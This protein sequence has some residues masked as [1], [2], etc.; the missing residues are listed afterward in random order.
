MTSIQWHHSK[1]IVSV[2]SFRRK[3]WPRIRIILECSYCY[4]Y[5]KSTTLCLSSQY[6][7][8]SGYPRS[9]RVILRMVTRSQKKCDSLTNCPHSCKSLEASKFTS[10]AYSWRQAQCLASKRLW[11]FGSTDWCNCGATLLEH[12]LAPSRIKMTS[13]YQPTQR[14]TELLE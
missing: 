13:H 11:G 1:W 6:L 9:R 4:G 12:S 8:C 5:F 7:Y 3:A 14:W 10:D 2:T